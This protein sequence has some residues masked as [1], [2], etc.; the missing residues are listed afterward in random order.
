MY[1]YCCYPAGQEGPIAG[2]EH[3]VCRSRYDSLDVRGSVHHSTIHKEKSK[4]ATMYQNFII[5]YLYGAQHVSGYTPPIIRSLKLHWQ[6]LVFHTWNV[7]G[8]I[9]GGRVRHT[10]P[11]NVHQLHVQHV[12]GDTPPII[13]SLKTALT[14]SGFSYVECCWTCS[15]WTSGTLCLTTST[16]Y[17]SN[18][19]RA[20]HRPSSGA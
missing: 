5:P 17:T 1:I 11:D 2:G 7:V 19:F 10:V 8:R 6:S 18:M 16:S 3:Q 13:R 20:T 15:W 4:D 14:A 9:V 12:S